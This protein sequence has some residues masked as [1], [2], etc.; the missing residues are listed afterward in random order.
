MKPLGPITIRPE[1][2]IH[3][4]LMKHLIY[5]NMGYL[6]NYTTPASGSHLALKTKENTSDLEE[7]A[8]MGI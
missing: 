5:S 8:K 2:K 4:F 1:S 3:T 7:P 6:R